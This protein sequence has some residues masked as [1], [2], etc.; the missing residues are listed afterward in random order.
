MT[1]TASGEG[2]D[3]WDRVTAVLFLYQADILLGFSDPLHLREV[4]YGC[5]LTHRLL[6][7]YLPIAQVT[8][9]ETG[10]NTITVRTVDMFICD[11][12]TH[13]QGSSGV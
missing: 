4:W 12:S 8:Q 3:Y 9:S 13:S 1:G 10:S 11:N 6:V 5:A 2:S 7:L